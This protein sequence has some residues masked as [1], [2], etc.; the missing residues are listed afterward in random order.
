M[1]R[2]LKRIEDLFRMP[3]VPAAP[4]GLPSRPYV[5]LTEAVTW[6]AF[7]VALDTSSFHVA[8]EYGIGPFGDRATLIN[9]IGEAISRFSVFAGGGVLEVR[10]RYVANYCDHD[11]AANADTRHMT[12]DELTDFGRFDSLY[13]GLERGSG[14]TWESLP[15]DRLLTGRGD[16]WRNV[17]VAR[18]GLLAAFPPGPRWRPTTNE[19]VEWCQQWLIKGHGAG[20]RRAWAEFRRVP[21]FAGLS[22]DDAFRPAFKAAKTQQNK[23]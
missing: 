16:G 18:E 19:L 2:D 12:K 11:A 21:A 17:E 20:E 14:T 7:G 22:R 23:A 9:Q 8:D 3:I 10:G 13:G 15:L 5:T 4:A 6:I 1:S